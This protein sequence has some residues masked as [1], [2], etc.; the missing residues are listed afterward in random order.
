MLLVLRVA[1]SIMGW[2]HSEVWLDL[3]A[4]LSM[5]D[6]AGLPGWICILV[7]EELPDIAEQGRT[8]PPQVLVA[9]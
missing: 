3:L 2:A 5:W 1:C 6:Y 8:G 7:A 9:S 4:S